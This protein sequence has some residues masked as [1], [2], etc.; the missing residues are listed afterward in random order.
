MWQLTCGA[1]WDAVVY[2]DMWCIMIIA[3]TGEILKIKWGRNF[4]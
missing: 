2:A 1:A 3:R 4:E